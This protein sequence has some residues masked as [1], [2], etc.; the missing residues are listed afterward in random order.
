MPFDPISYSLAK[1]SV[2]N[3]TSPP[4]IGKFWYD[5]NMGVLKGYDFKNSKWKFL[6]RYG[7]GDFDNSGEGLWNWHI[8]IPIS[9]TPSESIQY[10]IEINGD[11]IYVKSNDLT[12]NLVTGTGGTT[13]WQN[14]SGVNDIRVFDEN[15]I[16][17]YFWIEEFD[18]TNQVAKIWVKLNAGQTMIGIAFGNPYALQSQYHNGNIV[19]EFF[20]DFSG[21]SL[22][23]LSSQGWTSESYGNNYISGE[24]KVSDKIYYN[25]PYS[26]LT[27]GSWD[28]TSGSELIYK[29]INLSL[30]NF[31]LE[32]YM[33]QLYDGNKL[34]LG[35]NT[36]GGIIGAGIDGYS[37]SVPLYVLGTNTSFN[38]FGTSV[39]NGKWMKTVLVCDGSS[40][41][42]SVGSQSTTATL[43]FSFSN[44]SSVMIGDYGDT[45]QGA[46]DC[47]FIR[48]YISTDLTFGT[49]KVDIF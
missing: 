47:V 7:Y 38:D 2:I 41:N 11:N 17:N 26:A 35:V 1:K 20:D 13:F 9:T 28:G 34:W 42:V 12:T 40:I 36:D 29:T 37:S 44:I 45:E 15:F 5:V 43:G 39:T 18:T 46:F 6:A 10:M 19:F 33:V 14:V 21:Y 31:I 27:S 25:P 32:F 16:Q 30:S 49:P 23:S 22:G 24:I 48:K 8:Q 4:Y 3:S